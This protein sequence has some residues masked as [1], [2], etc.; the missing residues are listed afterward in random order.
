M[1]K[2]ETNLPFVLQTLPGLSECERQNKNR[3]RVETLDVVMF[4][5]DLAW[6]CLSASI[7]SRGPEAAEPKNYYY[8]YHYYCFCCH[9]YLYSSYLLLL[10]LLFLLIVLIVC[11]ILNY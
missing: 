7:K 9:N 3:A 10:Y 4:S 6:T 8:P 11:I 2:S 5:A 1:P